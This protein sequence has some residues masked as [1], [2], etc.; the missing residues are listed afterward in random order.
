M[1]QSERLETPIQYSIATMLFLVKDATRI[2]YVHIHLAT[3]E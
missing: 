2:V 3:N 1:D